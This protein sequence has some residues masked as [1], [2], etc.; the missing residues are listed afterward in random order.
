MP[1]SAAAIPHVFFIVSFWLLVLFLAVNNYSVFRVL[2]KEDGLLENIQFIFF[3]LSCGLSWH[4]AIE[5]RRCGEKNTSIFFW[6]GVILFF[7][8]A[9]EEISWGQRIFAIPT[10]EWLLPL[11]YQR[12]LNLHNIPYFGMSKIYLFVGGYGVFSGAAYHYFIDHKKRS[13]LPSVKIEFLVVPLRYA[14]Y[15]MPIFIWGAFPKTV[16]AWCVSMRI[17]GSTELV[18]FL[19]AFGCYLTLFCHLRSAL[20]SPPP[21]S[22][23]K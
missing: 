11:N 7:F 12:E 22:R 13:L 20:R 18:E 6:L 4:L 5:M 19:F 1:R 9:M 10:P 23:K 3:L 15:F 8:I 21:R 14:L 16:W 2:V 17:L